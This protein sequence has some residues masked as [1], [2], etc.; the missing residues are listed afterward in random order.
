MVTNLENAESCSPKNG[1]IK[2]SNGHCTGSGAENGK[3]R[4]ALS[5]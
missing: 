5:H 4:I 3:W 1:R 2:M